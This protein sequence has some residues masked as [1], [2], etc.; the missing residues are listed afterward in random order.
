VYLVLI[1]RLGNYH[2]PAGGGSK[3]QMETRISAKGKS[4]SCTGAMA[5][6]HCDQT[7]KIYFCHWR[8]KFSESKSR[9]GERKR[10]LVVQEPKRHEARMQ[11]HRDQLPYQNVP[12]FAFIV[13]VGPGRLLIGEVEARARPLVQT[14]VISSYAGSR[15]GVFSLREA[16]LFWVA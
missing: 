16:R 5:A 1:E 8:K 4:K 13:I 11:D 6:A 9:V 2:R 3:I 14:Q 12:Q 10:A 7:A 15:I